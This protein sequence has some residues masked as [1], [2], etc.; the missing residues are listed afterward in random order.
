[1]SSKNAEDGLNGM[2]VNYGTC[3]NHYTVIPQSLDIPQDE[4]G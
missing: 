1:M 4:K 3:A 2:L